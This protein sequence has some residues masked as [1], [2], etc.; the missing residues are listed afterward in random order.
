MALSAIEN[1]LNEVQIMKTR[2]I[3]SLLSSACGL[4]L[5]SGA[6]PAEET[7]KVLSSTPVL[8]RVTEPKSTCTVESDGRQK[9]VTQMVTEDRLIGYKV[10]YEYAGKTHEVQLPFPP[11]QTIPLEISASPA[12]STA[13]PNQPQPVYS[14]QPSVVVERIVREPVYVE[15]AYYP[16]RVYYPGYYYDPIYPIVG[17]A[18]GYS[19]GS[20]GHGWRGHGRYVGHGRWPR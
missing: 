4:A 13:P 11:G 1:S 3:V 16:S 14:S 5:F 9:C 6:A 12:V 7:G 19:W 18:L 20:W 10:A 8:K 2:L 15:P 17:L